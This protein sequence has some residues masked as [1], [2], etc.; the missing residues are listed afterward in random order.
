[1]LLAL[2]LLAAAPVDLAK[3]EGKEAT[4]EGV[5]HD[6]KGGAILLVDNN[7]IYLRGIEAWPAAKLK[8]TV[9][10]KGTLR[11]MKLLPSPERQKNGAISQGAEGIQ[12]VLLNPSWT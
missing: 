3:L 1:M 5:A 6:A 9:K 10:V 11:W 12:W 2:M 8:Q 7:P 4:L